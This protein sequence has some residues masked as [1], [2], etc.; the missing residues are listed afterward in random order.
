MR[1]GIK[2]FRERIAEVATGDEVVVVT[3][4]GKRVGRFVPERARQKP[5]DVDVHG[6][7]EERERFGREWRS[8]TPDWKERLAVAGFTSEEIAELDA[9]DQCS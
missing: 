6:W 9:D 8:A 3:H 2:E 5:G 7:A 1:M 4:R